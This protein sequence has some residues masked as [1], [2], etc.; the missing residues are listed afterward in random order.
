MTN[1]HDDAPRPPAWAAPGGSPQPAA[2]PTTGAQTP[3]SGPPAAPPVPAGPPAQPAPAPTGWQAAPGWQPAPGQQAPPAPGWQTAPGWQPPGWRPPALQPGIVPLRPL[4]LG[5]ILDGS[6]RAVRANPRVMF[7][8]AALVVTIGVVIQTVVA[9]YLRGFLDQQTADL[10]NQ[11]DPNGDLGVGDQLGSSLS[12]VLT[13]PVL[14]L[15]TTVLT[16]LVIVS[17]SRSVL[18]QTVSIGEVL[19][20]TRVWWVVGFS[21]LSAVAVGL[22]VALVVGAVV[23]LAAG[24]GIGAAAVVGVLLAIGLV[25]AGAWFFVRTLLVPAALMLEGKGFWR[26][27]ARA[28][29]LTR[30]SYWRLLGIYLLAAIIVGVVV[31]LISVPVATVAAF[32]FDGAEQSFGAIAIT[33]LA[34]IVAET[35]ATTFLA[36]VVALLYIDV[37]MRREGLDVELARAAQSAA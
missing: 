17:V 18:G 34:S 4:G 26:T 6:F 36:S 3:P 19:R 12:T 2:S 20:S 22:V 14:S 30:G 16:G 31:Q 23:G 33:A 21:L 5:E 28:W 15:A 29:R 37:R 8:V 1:P 13:A 11:I 35:L 10:A 25:V 32:V 24:V 7:G 27:V 9:W